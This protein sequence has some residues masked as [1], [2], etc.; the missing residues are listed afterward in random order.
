MNATIVALRT[1]VAM[2][3]EQCQESAAVGVQ[4]V[5]DA[6]ELAAEA[7]G[8]CDAIVHAITSTKL[9]ATPGEILGASAP[10]PKSFGT[11]RSS[12]LQAQIDT[13]SGTDTAKETWPAELRT[14]E[15]RTP[16]QAELSLPQAGQVSK[17]EDRHMDGTAILYQRRSMPRVES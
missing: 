3:I 9:E 13:S 1:E 2:G 12:A 10:V 4:R 16:D 14:S 17:E 5:N 8:L 6:S 15:S 7:L 11:Q